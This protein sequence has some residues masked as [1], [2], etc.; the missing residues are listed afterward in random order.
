[1][2]TQS[3][4]KCEI[5][6]KLIIKTLERHYRRHLTL[7]TLIHRGGEGV[8]VGVF[9]T[10]FRL[11]KWCQI[12]QSII[13]NYCMSHIYF[14]SL[15]ENTGYVIPED[16]HCTKSTIKIIKQCQWVLCQSLFYWL[17]NVYQGYFWQLQKGF[18]QESSW[19]KECQEI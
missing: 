15:T 8:G 16:K 17:S 11:Y 9:F 3:N 19:T 6:S 7:Y 10:F 18:R 13:Y 14:L 1:M 2:E 12:A 5:W 4:I